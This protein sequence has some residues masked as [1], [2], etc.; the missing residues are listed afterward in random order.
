MK[1]LTILILS[2][3]MLTCGKNYD[4]SQVSINNTNYFLTISSCSVVGSDGGP[5]IYKLQIEFREKDTTEI[6]RL[7]NFSVRDSDNNPKNLSTVGEHSAT[8]GANGEIEFMITGINAYSDNHYTYTVQK[9]NIFSIVLDE[10]VS[11]PETEGRIVGKGYIHIKAQIDNQYLS[12]WD[13]DASTK[14]DIYPIQKIYFECPNNS[15]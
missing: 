8:S 10:I 6:Y 11:A 1:N 3:F 13:G 5:A 2:A 14:N 9:D 12:S 4:N 7:V 15:D